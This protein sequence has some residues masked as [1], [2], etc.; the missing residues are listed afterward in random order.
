MEGVGRGRS[1]GK[2]VV[3][4]HLGRGRIELMCMRGFGGLK[5]GTASGKA[6]FWRSEGAGRGRKGQE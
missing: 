6:G 1:R 5:G 3:A 4:E 2:V